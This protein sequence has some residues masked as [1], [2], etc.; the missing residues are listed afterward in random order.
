[1]CDDALAWASLAEAYHPAK[2]LLKLVKVHADVDYSAVRANPLPPQWETRSSF[3]K[4]HVDQ[5]T[6]LI[7]HLQG[8]LAAVTRYIGGPHIG[9]HRS[10]AKIRRRLSGRVVSETLDTLEHLLFNGCPMSISA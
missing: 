5:V 10:P 6:A 7:L 3:Y 1:M 9:S 4:P 2:V 8:D